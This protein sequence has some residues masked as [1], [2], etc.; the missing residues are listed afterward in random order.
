MAAIFIGPRQTTGASLLERIRAMDAALMPSGVGRLDSFRPLHHLLVFDSQKLWNI[1]AGDI[2]IKNADAQAL[3]LQGTGQVDGD[4][5]LAHAPF[6][7]GDD[8]LVLDPGHAVNYACALF[9]S[10]LIL[11]GALLGAGIAFLIIFCH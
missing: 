11:A 2:G 8:D 7:A 6:A 10:A 3:H 1:G 4:G 5:A 9:S